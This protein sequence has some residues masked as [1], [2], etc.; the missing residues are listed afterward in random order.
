MK[1]LILTTAIIAATLC[2]CEKTQC[3]N[4]IYNLGGFYN[5]TLDTYGAV[6]VIDGKDKLIKPNKKINVPYKS[7]VIL[8]GKKYYTNDC[9]RIW[10]IID[11]PDGSISMQ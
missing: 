11:H 2:G 10:T 8:D 1:K 7:V 4:Q 6:V 5:V 3:K 9:G